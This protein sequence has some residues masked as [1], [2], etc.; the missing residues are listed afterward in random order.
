MNGLISRTSLRFTV[1]LSAC[2]LTGFVTGANYHGLNV[3]GLFSTTE[4]NYS[5]IAWISDTFNTKN[6]SLATIDYPASEIQSQ[7]IKVAEF[8]LPTKAISRRRVA[9]LRHQKPHHHNFELLDSVVA[10]IKVVQSYDLYQDY[11][12]ASSKMKERFLYVMTMPASAPVSI[13]IAASSADMKPVSPAP[14][15]VIQVVQKSKSAKTARTKMSTPKM[16][17]QKYIPTV[18]EALAEVKIEREEP[19]PAVTQVNKEPMTTESVKQIHSSENIAEIN[20]GLFST[21]EKA[22]A[23]DQL[24][25]QH[26][27]NYVLLKEPVKKVLPIYAINTKPQAVVPS[28]PEDEIDHNNDVDQQLEHEMAPIQDTLVANKACEVLP[29]LRLLKPINNKDAENI[30]ICPAQKEWISKSWGDHGWVKATLDDYFP[31]LAHYPQSNSNDALLL[32]QN[33]VALLA[34]KSGIHYERGMGM[35]LGV[36]PTGYKI[37]FSGRSEEVQYFE[38]SEKKYFVILNVEPGAGVTE[39]VSSNDQNENA[40]IFTPVLADTITYLDLVAPVTRDIAV[41]VVKTTDNKN[42]NKEDKSADLSGLTVGVSTQTQVQAITQT[43]GMAV[44]R[45]VKLVPG[46][47]M[48]VDV[49]SKLN[50][51]K[52]YQ[53]RYEL[54][55]RTRN[56]VFVLKQYPENEIFQWLRQIKANIS[57]QSGMIFGEFNRKRLDGFKKNYTTRVESI[58]EKFGL[59][60]KNY[61]VLWNEKLSEQDPLEGDRP[62]FLSV[63]VPEGLAQT[64][65]INES[66]QI[67]Q[68]SLIPVSPRV[69]N[70]ISE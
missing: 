2:L 60:A 33:S 29:K 12:T 8:H 61:T 43:N 44:L 52:S 26:I 19:L 49:S 50:G 7:E 4:M 5:K 42:E 36:L 31:L 21:Q 22:A 25:N 18:E 15:T 17:T 27:Q 62:R 58:S 40:T 32:D 48:Y 41:K 9:T 67:I 63:Q 53:Y 46:Y 20:T 30:Q 57:D 59:V 10:K 16:N 13:A 37:E 54:K 24:L 45:N 66:N 34:I 11:R 47:P 56:G 39:L 6:I 64:H 55:K 51:E 35:V 3:G 65:L 38:L 1:V 28:P 69:I 14:A 68:T 70:V 23:Q